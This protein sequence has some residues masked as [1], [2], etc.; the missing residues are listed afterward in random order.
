MNIRKN[1]LIAALAMLLCLA[2]CGGGELVSLYDGDVAA[3]SH[4][5]CGAAFMTPQSWEKQS[6]DE[7]SVVF[8]NGD[9]SISLTVYYEL[10]GFSYYSNQ[11]LLDMGRE[12]CGQILAEPE[13]LRE[14]NRSDMGGQLV[15]A[16]GS[17]SSPVP[18]EADASAV[19]EVLVL[20][21]LS[22]VRY[23]FVTVS[24][25][26]AYA[27][28]SRLLEEIYLSFFVNKTEDELYADLATE[29]TEVQ[30]ED[31]DSQEAE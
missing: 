26:A 3:Y 25:T 7:R 22:A 28:N 10:A 17:L 2:G 16:A 24:T 14:E 18:E 20:S 31:N 9:N 11:E 13:I 29:P 12:I 30:Q 27:E 8:V 4:P 6:E 21:P 15:T 23:Y 19:C 5:D 1:L